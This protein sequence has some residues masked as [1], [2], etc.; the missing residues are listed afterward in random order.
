[1]KV[2]TLGMFM[3]LGLVLLTAGFTDSAEPSQADSQEIV[4]DGPGELEDIL[5]KKTISRFYDP[6]EVRG[7]V[8]TELLGRQLVLLRLY[9]FS[10][11]S[12]HQVP[13]QFDEWTSDGY[14]IVDIGPEAN[15]ELGNGILDAQD[16]LAFM[17]R[18]AG[19]RVAKSFWPEGV[20]QG[21][22]IE[23]IDPLSGGQG[24]Y[25]L[26]QFSDQAP[27]ISFGTEDYLEYTDEV[28]LNCRTYGV[29]GTNRTWKGN[30]HKLLLH[31]HFWTTEE[32][33][34]NGKDFI[35]SLRF[36]FKAKMAFGAIRIKFNEGGIVGGWSK[37]KS[38]PVRTIARQWLALTLPLGLKSP[39]FYGDA[40]CYDT[41][42]FTGFQTDV[43]FNPKYVAANFT[44]M[45]GHD[46]H[47]PNAYGMKWYNSNNTDG[48][49]I[50]GVTSPMEEQYDS[51]ADT[52]RC[53]VGPNGWA[54]Y[55]SM[56]DEFYR[57]QAEI[58][59]R[60][61]DDK[62]RHQPPEYY[63]GDLG[64]VYS[65]SIVK[66]LKP[67][68]YEF[69]VDVFVPYHFYDPAGLRMD[70]IE[71]LANIRDNPIKVKAGSH[72]ETNT[73]WRVTRMEP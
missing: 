30:V 6:V 17:A 27:E 39:K 9:S 61:S 59:V 1:M 40:Y 13:F 4:P 56:W 38:G 42:G 65:E 58:N 53:V 63:P 26:L 60:Y 24:W 46:M 22:E 41:L 57:S 45:F 47:D 25:Y 34:G 21:I 64:Y 28:R 62:E 44:M 11:G 10:E 29:Q 69:Q 67:R 33:G 12:F 31:Q 18:D 70:L 35:D 20:E 72:E 51:S 36:R 2:Q 71:E 16:M 50:D 32:A 14:L 43:P 15:A 23:I 7:E 66:R 68:K 52:W 8:L 48:F 55:R 5:Q 49:L 73:G 19:D 3:T 37:I 54:V